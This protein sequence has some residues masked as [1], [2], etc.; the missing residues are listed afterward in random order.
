LDESLNKTLIGIIKKLLVENKKSWDSKLKYA[1]WA[2]M[3]ITKNSLGTS[4]F[5][6][7]YGLDVVF[8]TQLGLPVLKFLQEEAKEPNDIHR[9]IFQIIEVQQTR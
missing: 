6:L 8:P 2:D 4:P 1:L 3:I 7:V 5:Q 9:M